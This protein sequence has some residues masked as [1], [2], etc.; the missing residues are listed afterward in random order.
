MTF[1]VI[2]SIV[3]QGSASESGTYTSPWGT[4]VNSDLLLLITQNDGGGDTITPDSDFITLVE[5]N[6]GNVGQTF[7]YR[8]CDGTETGN[9]TNAI[10]SAESYDQM[11]IRILAANWH[12]TTPPEILLGTQVTSDSPDV[13]SLNPTGWATEDTLWISWCTQDQ[14][15]ATISTY[16]FADNNTAATT[17]GNLGMCSEESAVAANDPAA[18][19]WSASD[20]RV[21][22][23]I[24]V[25]PAAGGAPEEFL[26]RQYPQGV[27]RGVMRGAI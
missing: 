26:G 11:L 25:R 3:E 9:F 19:L 24:A 13:G 17:N 22:S 6:Q 7:A 27:Q 10:S 15:A 4:T 20:Q 12:G 8:I 14:G 18:W 2:T 16:P 23:I 21:A 5:D 1:P